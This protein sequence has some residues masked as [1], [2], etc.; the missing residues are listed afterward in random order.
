VRQRGQRCHVETVQMS[1][2]Q[3]RDYL[4]DTCRCCGSGGASSASAIGCDGALMYL[5]AL[6]LCPGVL[7]GAGVA[8]WTW[9]PYRTARALLLSEVVWLLAL[10]VVAV[11]PAHGAEY[12]W[13]NPNIASDLIWAELQNGRSYEYALNDIEPLM[14]RELA[15]AT[16]ACVEEQ[17]QRP[18]EFAPFR[19][20]MADRGWWEAS[21]KRLATPTVRLGRRSLRGTIGSTTR[22]SSPQTQRVARSNKFPRGILS[23][24]RKPRLW[25]ARV[26]EPPKS[27]SSIRDN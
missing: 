7:I 8:A 3:L 4:G 14:D 1:G 12:R 25:A 22:G 18:P 13:I 9:S 11:L 5:I 27:K 24:V 19:D 23:D 21:S 20:C 17:P 16:N 6:M 15:E 10:A 2:R 26:T